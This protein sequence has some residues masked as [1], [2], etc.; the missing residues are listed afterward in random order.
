MRRGSRRGQLLR[1][2]VTLLGLA[3]SVWLLLRRREVSGGTATVI[4][5]RPAAVPP[6]LPVPAAESRRDA[7]STRHDRPVVGMVGDLTVDDLRAIRGIGPAIEA[8]LH[9]LGI[10]TFAE[11][12]A[13]DVDGQE[14]VRA[15]LRDGTGRMQRD[16]W[17]GQAREL[18]RAKY[19]GD[20]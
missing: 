20:F 7:E 15:E 6:P 9:R 14:R 8:T 10:H 18:H 3:A 12:A 4:P 1:L 11:L 13:L 19:G 5:F 2:L 17:Q 16:D